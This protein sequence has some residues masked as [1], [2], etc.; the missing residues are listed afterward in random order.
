MGISYGIC[1][2]SFN[3]QKKDY[4]YLALI[5]LFEP[6]LYFVGESYALKEMSA[7]TVSLVQNI[8]PV[9]LPAIILLFRAEKIKPVITIGFISSL[10]G[11]YLLYYSKLPTWNITMKGMLYLL[12]CAGSILFYPVLIKK[13]SSEYPIRHILFVQYL[14]S[15]LF[16]LPVCLFNMHHNE[17]LSLLSFEQIIPII[18]LSIFASLIACLFYLNAIRQLGVLNT[19]LWM[20]LIP[21]ITFLIECIKLKSGLD[22]VSFLGLI[23]ILTGILSKKLS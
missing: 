22:I 19:V 12:L 16:L 8:I 1:R 9:F 18:E 15:A 13:L 6:C 23:M 20:N 7:T 5:S 17:Y 2:P 14:L 21:L 10:S 11:V 3:F 4:K